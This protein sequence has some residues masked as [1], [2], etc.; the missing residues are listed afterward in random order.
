MQKLLGD[1]RA[2][3]VLLGPALLLYTAIM[4]V[5]IFWSIGYT[6][7]DGN[8]IRGFEFVGFDN[9]IKFF[10]DPTAW[11]TV[12]FT[13]RYALIMTLLQV[14]FGYL[15][16]MLYIFYL[17]KSSALIRTVV[18]FPVVLPTVA[19]ALLF[20]KLFEAAPTVGPVNVILE[21]IGL[22]G[23]DWFG[24]ARPPRSPSSS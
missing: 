3:F 17:R 6:A 10:Q 20:Q 19:V 2:V 12:G 7:F 4:L 15:L 16:A 11:E 13:I 24:H 14:G 9:Y 1:R 8:A 18:F 23:V 21:A 5:P 22:N